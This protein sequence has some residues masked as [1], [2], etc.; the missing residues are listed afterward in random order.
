MFVARY[1]DF[2]VFGDE[3]HAGASNDSLAGLDWEKTGGDSKDFEYTTRIAK[4]GTS[5][6]TFLADIDDYQDAYGFSTDCECGL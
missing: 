1:T 5:P 4:F 6:S 2:E 3:I